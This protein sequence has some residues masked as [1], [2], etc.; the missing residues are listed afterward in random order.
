MKAKFTRQIAAT[1][2]AVGVGIS[3]HAVTYFSDD[4]ES[5]LGQ[6]TVGS[7]SIAY[8]SPGHGNVMTFSTTAQGGD[9]WTTG[10]AVP[11]V[12]S[13]TQLYLNFDY[14]GF[15]G[16]IGVVPHSN[17]WLAGEAGYGSA[18]GYQQLIYG[19]DWN[20]YE[21]T[22]PAGLTGQLMVEDWTDARAHGAFFDNITISDERRPTTN[23]VPEGGFTLALLGLSLGAMGWVRRK[24]Q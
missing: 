23:Q 24:L 10:I 13:G 14:K 1:A 21:I 2:L 15:G 12:G 7:A 6:W 19:Q 4:F 5:G 9:S 16:Y 11:V 18:V 8:D 3:A 17:N 20:H 22:I